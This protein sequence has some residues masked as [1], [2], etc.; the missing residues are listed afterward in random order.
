[1][2]NSCPD[3]GSSIEFEEHEVRLRTG[4]CPACAQEFAF[5][6]GTLV[7]SSLGHAGSSSSDQARKGPAAGPGAP[8]CEECGAPLTFRARKDGA[9]EAICEDCEVTTVYFTDR[10]PPSS[11][12]DRSD[13]FEGGP[14]RGRPCRQCGAP[15]RFS[16]DD[17]GNLVGECDACGN[18][19]VL[20]PRNRGGG[21][22]FDRR[23]G[24]RDGR[25][26]YRSSGEGRRSGPA[27][28]KDRGRRPYRKG[29]GARAEAS[30]AEPRRTRRRR[31]DT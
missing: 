9:L 28:G 24:G 23:R 21:Q 30:D 8:E 26:D 11:G 2:T 12:R 16:T 7:S 17:D 31:W 25:R 1:M 3:C 5:V 6:E 19:F 15:L 18:R 4:K 22:P 20:P 27:Y 29:S 10:R 13:R 14:P